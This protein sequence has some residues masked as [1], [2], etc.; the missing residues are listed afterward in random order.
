MIPAAI[1]VMVLL[2]ACTGVQSVGELGMRGFRVVNEASGQNHQLWARETRNGRR[3]VDLCVVPTVQTREYYWRIRVL[4]DDKEV[5]SDNNVVRSFTSGAHMECVTSAPLPAGRL[6][7][8][9]SFQY[10]VSGGEHQPKVPLGGP[11]QP[12]R[13][14]TNV[15]SRPEVA[16]DAPTSTFAPTWDRGD[17]WKFRWSSPRG[18]GTFVRT[19]AGETTI[20][21]VPC[22]ILRTGSRDIYYTKAD[23]AWLMEHVEGAVETRATPPNRLL[24]WPLFAGKTWDQMYSWENPAARLT[25]E[26]RRRYTVVAW[27]IVNVPAG[28][29]WTYHVTSKDPTGRLVSEYWYAP[30]VKWIVK[31]RNMHSYGVLEREMLGYTLKARVTTAP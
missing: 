24:D 18:A 5:W 21:G 15:A 29:F 8:W 31:D 2:T 22:Y 13:A 26:R 6:A 30:E 4:A 25:E 9:M 1:L 14:E 11:A 10:Q 19:V 3:T 27:V 7:Y 16:R 17:E 28:S 12:E 23:L 20:A